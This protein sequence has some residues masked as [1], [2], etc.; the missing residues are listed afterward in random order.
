MR[1]HLDIEAQYSLRWR[2]VF[3]ER[4]SVRLWP[5]MTVAGMW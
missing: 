5:S 1:I 3:G 4:F 2:G